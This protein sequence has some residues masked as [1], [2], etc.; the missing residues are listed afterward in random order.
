[1]MTAKEILDQTNELARRLYGMQ[2]YKVPE[3]Y[4]FDRAKHPHERACWAMAVEAQALLTDTYVEDAIN[5]LEE[6]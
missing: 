5:E 3:G 2:G 4:R 1:M 6:E